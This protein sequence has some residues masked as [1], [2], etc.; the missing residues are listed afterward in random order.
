MPAIDIIGNSIIINEL[1]EDL[2]VSSVELAINARKRHRE[3]SLESQTHAGEPLSLKTITLGSLAY[4]HVW[5]GSIANN[6]TYIDDY[7][8]PWTYAIDYHK[9]SSGLWA[10]LLRLVARGSTSEY[11][12]TY[13]DINIL[14]PYWLT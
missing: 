1:V 10:P 12:D 5:N 6:Y 11:P 2:A 13:S 14:K 9:N 4:R 3:N 7:L 8:T